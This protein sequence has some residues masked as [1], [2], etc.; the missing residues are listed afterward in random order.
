MLADFKNSFILGFNKEFAIKS[1]SLIPPYTPYLYLMK[2]KKN[3][4]WQNSDTL[5]TITST[6]L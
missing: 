5:N 4:K 3:Q 1:M 2:C 6:Y